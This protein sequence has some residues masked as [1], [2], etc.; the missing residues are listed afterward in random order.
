[1]SYKLEIRYLIKEL[2][3]D[4]LLKDPQ[5]GIAYSSGTQDMYDTWSGYE[6]REAAYA[7]IRVKE[8]E[9]MEEHRK[10][11]GYCSSSKYII[12]EQVRYVDEED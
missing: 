8:V 7:A 5:E 11:W 1:M 12:L 10:K 2:S 4:G 9:E 6:T 3:P